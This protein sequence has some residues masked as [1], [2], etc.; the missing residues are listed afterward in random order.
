MQA[1]AKQLAPSAAS[2]VAALLLSKIVH[3]VCPKKVDIFQTKIEPP[4]QFLRHKKP[5]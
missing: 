1:R 3:S 4:Q 2:F 5:R